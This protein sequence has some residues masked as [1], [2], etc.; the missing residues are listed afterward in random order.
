L[1]QQ[2]E[3]V[4]RHAQIDGK[5]VAPMGNTS[6]PPR[7]GSPAGPGRHKPLGSLNV[8]DAERGTIQQVLEQMVASAP[9]AGGAAE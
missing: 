6:S 4:S 9:V 5:E 1:P 8:T 2:Q 3:V 7:V